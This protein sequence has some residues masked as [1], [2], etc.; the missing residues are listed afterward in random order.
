LN[1]VTEGRL[2]SRPQ[3]GFDVLRA[4]FLHVSGEALPLREDNI[5]LQC[6]LAEGSRERPH[7]IFEVRFEEVLVYYVDAICLRPIECMW[8]FQSLVA[9]NPYPRD[10]AQFDVT[11]LAAA[12]MIFAKQPRPASAWTA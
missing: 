4:G 6:A 8:R 3:A 2:L 7:V 10:Q 5:V 11:G 1:E 12:M 9:N